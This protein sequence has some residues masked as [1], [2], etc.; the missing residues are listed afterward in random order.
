MLRTAK[1]K[2]EESLLARTS[3]ELWCYLSRTEGKYCDRGYV[4][5]VEAK[6]SNPPH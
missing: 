2:D 6:V 4:C 3:M 5:L 1:S